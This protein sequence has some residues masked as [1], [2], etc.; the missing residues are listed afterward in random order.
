M[1][2]NDGE[3]IPLELDL[4][5]PGIAYPKTYMGAVYLAERDAFNRVAIWNVDGCQPRDPAAGIYRRLND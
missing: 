4:M 5:L 1:R 2:V 3:Y